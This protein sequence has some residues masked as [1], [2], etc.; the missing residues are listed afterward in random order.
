MGKCLDL[1]KA[2]Q[3]MAVHPD[4]RH[5]AVLFFFHSKDGSPKFYVANSLMF[6]A[7]AA[8]YSFN[9]VS[10]SLWFLFNRMLKIP[11]GVF[12]D[13]YPLFS[14]SELAENADASAGALL[15]LLGWKHARTGPQGLPF[16]RKFQVLVMALGSGSATNRLRDLTDF[17]D[18]AA[19][20]LQGSRPRIL[21]AF[22]EKR[23]VLV[24]TD[25]AWENQA[26]GIG[27]VLIDTATNMRW[28]LA[29]EVPQQL[30]D[31]WQPLVRDQLIC[32]VELYTMVVIR[33]MFRDFLKERRSLWWVDN[34]AARCAIIKGLSSSPTMRYLVREFYAFAV[35][36]PSFWWVERIPSFSK[37]L[38]RETRG[39]SEPAQSRPLS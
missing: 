14:P 7:T 20:A 21:S 16:E 17:C 34:D 19:E 31:K 4:H 9:R 38:Q 12:Y 1:R 22:C 18:Y 3:Q 27:A 5:L 2:Y 25:G 11:C 10:C 32:Q 36:A 39:S 8:V 33:W 35:E 15:D 24:F 28:V 13:E 29:G 30:L 26:A 6:G 23:P 37:A